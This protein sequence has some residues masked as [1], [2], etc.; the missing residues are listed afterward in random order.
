MIEIQHPTLHKHLEGIQFIDLFAGLGGFRLAM[1]SF[2]AECVFSS[3]KDVH[4]QDVYERN[5]TD[6]PHGDITKIAAEDIPQHDILCAGFPCQ[7]FSISGK[8]R[9]F[10][11]TRGTLFFD[12]ARIIKTCQPKVVFL[13]NVKNFA[14]HDKGRTI[15]T[16]QNTMNELGYDF[17]YKVLNATD[18][19]VPQNRARI[20]MVAFRR[21]LKIQNF[22]FPESIPLKSHVEDILLPRDG[23]CDGVAIKDL[24]VERKDSIW[25]EQKSQ[26]LDFSKTIRLGMVGKGG[27]GERIYSPKGV[28]ITLSAHGGGIFAKTGGYLIEGKVRRL[29]PRECARLSGF[30]DDY[31]LSL[32]SNQAYTQFGNTVVVDVLQRILQQIIKVLPL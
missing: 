16:V 18:F 20:Y 4:A 29:H 30:P 7:A 1:E 8:Q 21:D 23:I 26:T 25:H 5:F 24:I 14:T 15:K 31:Q 13:E 19:G 10:E 27:Q 3:E 2:G 9:G 28:G 22:A 32:K 12:V 17:H 11:D 6:R